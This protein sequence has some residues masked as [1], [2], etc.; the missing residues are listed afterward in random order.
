MTIEWRLSRAFLNDPAFSSDPRSHPHFPLPFNPLPPI[1]PTKLI[2]PKA[3]T[4]IPR[5][6]TMKALV[7]RLT[8][9]HDLDRID[10]LDETDPFGGSYH[11]DGPY[12]AIGTNHAIPTTPRI[13]SVAAP[14]RTNIHH[15]KREVCQASAHIGPS[16]SYY[17][18][19]SFRVPCIPH[20]TK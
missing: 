20:N 10:E 8:S 19:S 15:S 5:K 14:R 17:P 7:R 4:T 12:E 16:R 13:H 6:A 1:P 3:N 18:S 2:P 9:R 11:H